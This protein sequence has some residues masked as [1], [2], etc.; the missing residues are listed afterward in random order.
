MA[1]DA[2]SFHL[3][4]VTHAAT[5]TTLGEN[6]LCVYSGG[7]RIDYET[8]GRLRAAFAEIREAVKESST[9]F[10]PEKREREISRIKRATAAAEAKADPQFAA[11]MATAARSPS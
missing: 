10:E 6:L 5:I 2:E 11:F 7:Y 4:M 9:V 1:T 3:T 8:A